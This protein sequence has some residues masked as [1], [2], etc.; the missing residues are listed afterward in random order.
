M[1]DKPNNIKKA[2]ALFFAAAGLSL[3]LSVSLWFTGSK[4]QGMYVGI[5]VPSICSAG[6]LILAGGGRNG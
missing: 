1:I 3:L 2:K 4:E 6:S 5:W